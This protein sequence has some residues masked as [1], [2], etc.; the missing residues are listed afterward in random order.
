MA[1]FVL[2]SDDDEDEDIEDSDDVGE[3][4]EL[5]D[6]ELRGIVLGD[7]FPDPFESQQDYI[8]F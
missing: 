6:L 2:S 4:D 3:G 5:I 8:K 1:K 7:P